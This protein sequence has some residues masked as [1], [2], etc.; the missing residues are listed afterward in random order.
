MSTTFNMSSDQIVTAALRKLAVLGDGQSPSA[1]QLSNGTQALNAMIKG[2][3]A[4]GMPLWAVAEKSLSLTNSRTITL[5]TDA[6]LKVTQA[7][8]VDTTSGNTTPMNPK[9]HYDYN[10]LNGNAATGW[11][12]NY[13]YEP[14]NQTGVLHLWPT[15]DAYSIANC[16]VKIVY[17][18]PFADM[19]AGTDTLDFP[20]YW[21]EAV[22]YGLAY[23]L[24]PEYGIPLQDRQTYA[25]D[26]AAF[27]N[28]ALSFGTEDGSFFIEP[29]WAAQ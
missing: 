12:I 4:K 2:F 18:R 24:A 22:I 27:L 11:P 14:L 20:Q 25:Q 3:I 10:L 13:W 26:A 19:V 29:D 1:T 16:Q 15:P 9:S 5:T 8:L 23:R 28:E 6:P 7:I 17:Q 21:L